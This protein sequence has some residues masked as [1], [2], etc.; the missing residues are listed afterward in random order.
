MIRH[1]G[2]L[3]LSKEK[4]LIVE[5]ER[6]VAEEIRHMLS[7]MGYTVTGI[8]STGPDA[9][10]AAGET[11]PDFILMDIYLKGSM[12][13][14]EAAGI[15]LERHN[16]PVIYLTAY[17]D[18]ATIHRARLTRPLGYIIKPLDRLQVNSVIEVALYRYSR[19]KKLVE[20]EQWL[21]ATLKTIENGIIATGCEGDIHFMN[22]SA[23]MLAGVSAARAN[24]KS[25][26]EIILIADINSHEKLP[27]F[28]M[29]NI[30][31]M[32]SG[33]TKGSA[34]LV[35]GDGYEIPVNYVISPVKDDKKQGPGFIVILHDISRRLKIETM[36]QD[37]A[38][39]HR[40]LIE[41]AGEGVM[42]L[43]ASHSIIFANQTMADML[44][45]PRDHLIGQ[46][47]SRFV[48]PDCVAT[49]YAGLRSEGDRSVKVC[50]AGLKK[51]D[52]SNIWA[53]I[54]INK[55]TDKDGNYTGALA[56]VTDVTGRKA[57]EI[58][59]IEARVN[60]KLYLEL[61]EQEI[62]KMNQIVQGY[63]D[64]TDELMD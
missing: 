9:I 60:T 16:I 40:S 28:F 2:V 46:P 13:G 1:R 58:K 35:S 52:G 19:E 27:G 15:I 45:Y 34:I 3:R 56:M 50:E 5:D 55:M 18:E 31:S 10:R 36:L 25:I 43:D 53:R 62:G 59:L 23:C 17:S 12:D 61:I 63:L 42:S 22:P 29:K 4:I 20:S 14:I 47:V 41:G 32:P 24:G 57:M 21:A 38:K 8:V 44:G 51:S 11:L 37:S 26:D 39:K 49:L 33:P 54:A 30:S 7:S 48:N 6:I 64:T